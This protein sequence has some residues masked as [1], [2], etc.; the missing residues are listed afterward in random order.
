M[1]TYRVHW[2]SVT[3]W[4][5]FPNILKIW[6][7][8]FEPIFGSLINLKHG[9]RGFR[10]LHKSIAGIQIY[11]EPINIS[12][13]QDAYIS[14]SIPGDACDALDVQFLHEF[15]KFIDGKYRTNVT[16]LDMAFDHV[17][18]TP[19]QF[20][21]AL[22]ADKVRTY[23]KRE[24]FTIISS[25]YQPQE[26]GNGVGCDTVQVGKRQSERI[27][28]VYNKRGFT[29][30]ELEAKQKRADGIAKDVMLKDPD[31]WGKLFMGHL[32]DFIDLV[33]D[34]D[35]GMLVDFWAEFVNS[36]PR[37]ALTVTDPRK[38][39]I[40]RMMGWMYYGVAPALSAVYDRFGEDEIEEIIK[41]GREN[42]GERYDLIL[43]DEKKRNK[44]DY[45]D[46]E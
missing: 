26:E 14:M 32:R 37:A 28:R 36:I 15:I 22:D 24:S 7:E 12:Q 19:E 16:R 21:Q 38:V 40:D 23:A 46:E 33:E 20:S 5:T 13:D 17:P 2:L 27:L 30:V 3:I 44:G 34:K 9:G 25:P 42:R 1:I 35:T 43:P 10:S 11:S 41:L 18:F 29:R 4:T 31:N 39:E 45:Y 8:Q 6:H